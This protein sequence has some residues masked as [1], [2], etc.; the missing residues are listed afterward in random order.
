MQCERNWPAYNKKLIQRGSVNL[1]PKVLQN[2]DRELRR[3]NRYKEG[4]Q[5]EYP[6]SFIKFL[7]I[8]KVQ[9]RFSYR[10]IIGLIQFLSKLCPAL[11]NIPCYTTLFRRANRVILDLSES[12]PKSN[13]PLF[14]SIDASGLKADNGGSWLEQRFGT[15]KRKWIK[16]HFA[17]D[18]K[19]KRIIELFV[20]TSKVH[21][22]RRFR[23]LVK[24]ASR[25]HKIDKVAADP[26]YDDYKNYELLHKKKIRAAI[27]PRL[28]SNPAYLQHRYNKRMLY[29]QKQ[30]LLFQ[31]YRYS[32]WRKKT[33][34]NYRT[35]NE[36][37]FS[38]FKAGYGDG[39]SSK[40]FNYVRQE[41]LWKAYAY[42][43][44]R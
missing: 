31:K 34:Y 2:W 21:D 6:D 11:K 44:S 30:V 41:V 16:I 4:H 38:A 28:N 10:K 15:K 25:N 39:V 20:T 14:I 22:N 19:S 40:K 42:N 24:K 18:T 9:F 33:G 12:I 7:G 3:M 29:R 26:G 43:L 36:S 32:T 8:L 23:G 5:F 13:E 27:K 17:I 37:C 35:L 1:D